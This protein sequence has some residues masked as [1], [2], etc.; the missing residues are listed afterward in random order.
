LFEAVKTA[1]SHAPPY[2][3]HTTHEQIPLEVDDY[4]L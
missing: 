3:G 4:F 1:R 2:S